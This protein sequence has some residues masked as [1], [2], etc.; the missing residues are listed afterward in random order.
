M[1]YNANRCLVKWPENVGKCFSPTIIYHC[2]TTI[3]NDVLRSNMIKL[4]ANWHLDVII[5]VH[6]SLLQLLIIISILF[7]RLLLIS[8]NCNHMS[9]SY[10]F[11]MRLLLISY[12]CNHMSMSYD[13]FYGQEL[14]KQNTLS[15][16]WCKSAPLVTDNLPI[17]RTIGSI[18][19][20]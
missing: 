2:E 1:I 17:G 4:Y 8:Y 20:I 13:F 3:F 14:A 5:I 7:M 6:H 9:M 16:C 11:F 19:A 10:D 12:N 18:Y 15:V